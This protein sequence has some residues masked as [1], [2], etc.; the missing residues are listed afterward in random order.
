MENTKQQVENYPWIKI[1]PRWVLGAIEIGISIYLVINFHSMFGLLFSAYWVLSLF[2]FLPLIRCTKCYYYG[3]RC[4]TAW[5][6]LAGFAFP[7]G[8]QVYFQTGY[9]LTI[10][11][12]PLRLMPIGIGL[13]KLLDGFTIDADGLFGLYLIIIFLHRLFYRTAN[14]PVCK[15]KDICPVYN[16]HVL[17]PE[18]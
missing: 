15:Q 14:C 2:V 9:G 4:N 3:K 11:L 12:W 8:N 1:V 16:P 6:L 17:S 10:I 13:L 18:S 5:G 7:K